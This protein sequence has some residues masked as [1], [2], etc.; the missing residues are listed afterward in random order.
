[1]LFRSAE[2]RNSIIGM[3]ITGTLTGPH[4]Y[5]KIYKDDKEYLN[6]F[7]Y[8]QSSDYIEC[9]SACL[10]DNQS[11]Y[12]VPD[13]VRDCEALEELIDN[14]LGGGFSFSYEEA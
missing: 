10:N 4:I 8:Q 11:R 6:K 12:L 2:I 1:M 3:H 7:D 13:D 5:E 9:L 14:L